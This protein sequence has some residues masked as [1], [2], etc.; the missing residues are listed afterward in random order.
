MSDF[1]IYED[2]IIPE[3]NSG[4]WLWLGATNSHGY[5]VI[6]LGG[7]NFGAHRLVYEFLCEPIDD[8]D[9]VLRHS[10][11]IRC[12]VN[13]KHLIVGTQQENIQDAVDR[14][15][16]ANGQRNGNAKILDEDVPIIRDLYA[17]G[18]TQQTIA[19]IYEVDRSTIGYIVRNKIRANPLHKAGE[20]TDE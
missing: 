8:D 1:T 2:K 13:P 10:C 15:R 5:G 6:K 12:C 17:N 16:T 18:M 9:A 7:K 14:N 4:C 3:P 11:D 19:D 20:R